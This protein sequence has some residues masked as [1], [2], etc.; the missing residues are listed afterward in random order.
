MCSQIS[1]KIGQKGDG[2][3]KCGLLQQ[4]GVLDEA[5]GATGGDSRS[6]PIKARAAEPGLAG[7]LDVG[8]K[9]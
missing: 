9:R 8:D 6:C 3:A 7:Y 2:K 4:R 5:E 1:P